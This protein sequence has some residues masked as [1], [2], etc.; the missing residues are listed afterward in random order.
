MRK[1]SSVLGFHGLSCEVERAAWMRNKRR[2]NN[3]LLMKSFDTFHV[4]CRALPPNAV[5][6]ILRRPGAVT[7]AA[8]IAL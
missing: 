5:A 7:G 3:S 1:S 8:A 2:A 4:A 6:R